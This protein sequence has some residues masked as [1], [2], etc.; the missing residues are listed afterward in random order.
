[1]S[2]RKIMQIGEQ[3][4]Y[5]TIIEIGRF[6]IYKDGDKLFKRPTVIAKCKCGRT[7][8]TTET[9]IRNGYTKSCGCLQKQATIKRNK[10]NAIHNMSHT[11]TFKT[12]DSM[13]ERCYN[14][15]NISYPNYGARGITICNRWLESFQNFYDDMGERP[16]GMTIDR[17]DGTKNYE[18]SNCKWSTVK[19]QASNRRTNRYIIMN[20]EK[21]TMSEFAKRLKLDDSSITKWAVRYNKTYQEAANYY[22]NK[23]ADRL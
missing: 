14:P 15:N 6:K 18:P 12:W 7:L 11:K 10:D 20:D 16:K 5:L 13:K 19:E 21:I 8:Q 2:P 4:G 1:M 23:Y 17:I 22:L 9:S 3:Y